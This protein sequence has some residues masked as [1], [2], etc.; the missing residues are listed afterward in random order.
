MNAKQQVTQADRAAQKMMN[1]QMRA[2]NAYYK[3]KAQAP[4]KRKARMAKAAMSWNAQ[5]TK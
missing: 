3:K 5:F 2:L 1:A 4:A